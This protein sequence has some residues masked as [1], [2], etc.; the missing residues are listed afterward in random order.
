[1]S[2]Q[3]LLIAAVHGDNQAFQQI[4]NLG[5]K[6]I[7]QAVRKQL[8][9]RPEAED[10]VQETWLR[11]LRKAHLFRGEAKFSTWA[12]RVAT[13]EAWMWYRKVSQPTQQTYSLSEPVTNDRGEQRLYREP[14]G[15]SL[16]P[17]VNL[18][19][20]KVLCAL[21]GRMREVLEMRLRDM[22]YAEIALEMQVSLGAVKSYM[23]RAMGLAAK[24]MGVEGETRYDI[25][26]AL[27]K[28]NIARRKAKAVGR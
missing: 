2:E 22:E 3:E 27:Q 18:D 17:W 26:R 24:V 6:V 9:D 7:R 16:T 4:Y 14:A 8:K 13:N 23:F 12:Y 28:K 1:M 15:K 21:N 11:I 19:V 10:V 5:D 20:Q 25:W